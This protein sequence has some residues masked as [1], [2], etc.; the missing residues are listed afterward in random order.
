MKRF[1]TIPILLIIGVLMLTFTSC[2]DIDVEED[3]DEMPYSVSY[4]VNEYFPGYAVSKSIKLDDGNYSI[5]IK[6][7]P[8]FV[9]KPVNENTYGPYAALISYTGNGDP[10]PVNLATD[11]LPQPVVDYLLGLEMINQ[12]FDM[13]QKGTVMTVSA[14]SST[15]IS[16]TYDNVTGT[17]VQL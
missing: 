6:D 16:I 10:M 11:K 5:T 3:N 8:T 4:T 9:L 17:I 7:G 15:P 13:W 14:G 12:I 2:G 1:V